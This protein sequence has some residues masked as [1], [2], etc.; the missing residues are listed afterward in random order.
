M[1]TNLV[2]R[3]EEIE[4]SEVGQHIGDLV[5][6]G[7]LRIQP[8][9]LKGFTHLAD[10]YVVIHYTDGEGHERVCFGKL[11]KVR[12]DKRVHLDTDVMPPRFLQRIANGNFTSEPVFAGATDA[13]LYALHKSARYN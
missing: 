13:R 7:I 3:T 6:K 8:F 4:N 2:D 11:N 12:D 9:T 10:R 5:T 1:T